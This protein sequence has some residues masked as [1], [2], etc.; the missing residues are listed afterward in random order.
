MMST[1]TDEPKRVAELFRETAYQLRLRATWAG[2][3]AVLRPRL[4]SPAGWKM[5][6]LPDRWF[7]LYY[8][9]GPFLWLR[10][11]ARRR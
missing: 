6:R 9:A 1:I 7:A 11:R 2:R 10:R 4:M 3:A 8:V 5:L